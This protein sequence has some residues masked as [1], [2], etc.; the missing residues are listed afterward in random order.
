MSYV[1]PDEQKGE[2]EMRRGFTLIEMMIVIA[3]IAILAGI[4]LPY[5]KGMQDEGN[6]AKAAGELRTLATAIESYY[7]HNHKE[8]PAESATWQSA[9]TGSSPKIVTTALMDPFEPTV[10]YRYA[11]TGKYYVVYSVGADS[12]VD[13]AGI[14]DTGVVSW[15]GAEDPNDDIYISNGT[16]GTGGF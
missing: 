13:I 9:L 5:F 1:L 6:T 14:S 2:N 10:Q 3:V 8:Y 4:S 11:T 7:I 16:S 12:T 15:A